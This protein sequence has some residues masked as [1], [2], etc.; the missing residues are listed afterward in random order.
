MR[1]RRIIDGAAFG[2]EVVKTAGAAFDLAWT[3]VCDRFD[4][5]SQ[6]AAREVLAVSIISAARKESIDAEALRRSGVNALARAFPEIFALASQGDAP[7]RR[8]NQAG[9]HL[10]LSR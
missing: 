1:V 9:T 4:G 3:N 10:L 8:K 6:E 5:S 2:P 7:E